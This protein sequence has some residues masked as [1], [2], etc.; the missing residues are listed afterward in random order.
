MTTAK[1][2]LNGSRPFRMI[3][4][5]SRVEDLANGVEALGPAVGAKTVFYVDG[6]AGNDSN[7]GV[8]GWEN[9]FKTLTVALA[10]SNADIASNKYGWAA[11]NVIYARGD[12]FTEDLDL[13][14]Q[15][16]DI[17]GVGSYDANPRPGLVGNHE[18][19]GTSCTGTRFFNF[20]FR[21]AHTAGADIFTLDTYS[22]GIQFIGCKFSAHAAIIATGAIIGV[23]TS[24]L[25][26][27]GCEFTGGFSDATIELSTDQ[28]AL[29]IVGNYIESGG[30]G[31][32]LKSTTTD[33]ATIEEEHML[34]QG[35]TIYAATECIMDSSGLALVVDNRC[36]SKQA[37][38]LNGVGVIDAEE[39][40]ALNNFIA[41]SDRTN[42]PWPAVQ[43]V[44]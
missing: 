12:T 19:T 14:A 16:T 7:S 6:N 20:F 2:P 28:R 4:G 38:G 32:D 11:R 8:G 27:L 36:V 1:A 15:K 37:S 18:P 5:V 21:G 31:I 25:Q 41:A 43:A 29:R 22:T 9:S 33:G 13:L 34:I 17:I 40:L 3:A 44:T 23:S 35:N 30:Q 42:M 10:A 39:N 24:D 26:I